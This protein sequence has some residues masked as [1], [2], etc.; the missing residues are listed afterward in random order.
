MTKLATGEQTRF[1]MISWEVLTPDG[2]MFVFIQEAEGKPV[3]ITISIGK[4]GTAIAAW[5]SCTSRLI[6][7]ALEKGAGVNEI[8]EELSGL[9]A[10]KAVR[11]S[12]TGVSIRS[13]PEGIAYVFMQYKN[14]KYQEHVATME[15]KPRL[16]VMDNGA[17]LDD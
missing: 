4:S 13:G 5:A 15:G 9:S 6:T 11:I 16:M 7:L 14:H 8:I 3:G 2:K 17:S 1:D 12:K 10:E